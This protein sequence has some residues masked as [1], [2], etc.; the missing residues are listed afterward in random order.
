M[1]KVQP[2]PSGKQL[3]HFFCPVSEERIIRLIGCKSQAQ[4]TTRVCIG[5]HQYTVA[6][7][8]FFNL[9][10]S[11]FVR[12]YYNCFAQINFNISRGYKFLVCVQVDCYFIAMAGLFL[13]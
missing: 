4:T 13:C 9:D 7:V 3:N 1:A 6:I 10:D 5:V 12:L 11:L 2:L 8:L